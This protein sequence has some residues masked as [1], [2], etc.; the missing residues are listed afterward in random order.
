MGDPRLLHC[1]N[2]EACVPP[3][4]TLAARP[5]R[6]V[7]RVDLRCM[8]SI[9]ANGSVLDTEANPCYGR[10]RE[11]ASESTFLSAATIL[12]EQA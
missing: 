3:A 7:A 10:M 5:V 1:L 2:A 12:K 4:L 9:P 11:I 6:R 8:L